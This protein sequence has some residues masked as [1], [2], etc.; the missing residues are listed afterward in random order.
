MVEQ[1]EEFNGKLSRFV[2]LE[3][4]NNVTLVDAGF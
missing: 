1:L 2:H 4:M 3:L